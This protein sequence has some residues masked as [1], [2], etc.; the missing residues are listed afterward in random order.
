MT[1]Y[2]TL[3]TGMMKALPIFLAMLATALVLLFFPMLPSPKVKEKAPETSVNPVHISTSGLI[4]IANDSTALKNSEATAS[5]PPIAK[6][7]PQITFPEAPPSTPEFQLPPVTAS[8]L[9]SPASSALEEQHPSATVPEV[10]PSPPANAV[11]QTNDSSNASTGQSTTSGDNTTG[12]DSRAGYG[13]ITNGTPPILLKKV[14]PIY[15]ERSRRL[16]Q[17]GYVIVRFEVDVK[18]KVQNPVIH[19]AIPNGHFERATINAIRQW[20]FQAA[21]DETGRPTT[22]RLQVRIDFK[23]KQGN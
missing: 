18:G 23:L 1:F 12:T 8:S 4:P 14:E 16:G 10:L 17:E 19:E 13:N 2:G 22:F 21:K 9:P 6:P 15:P 7:L 5:N 20:R 3:R 11:Q